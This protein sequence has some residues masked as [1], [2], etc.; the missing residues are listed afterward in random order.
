MALVTVALELVLVVTTMLVTAS[1]VVVGP[2]RIATALSEFRWRLEVCLLP[3]AAL[4][5]VLFVRWAT[6]DVTVRLEQRVIGYNLT[7]HLFEIE[8]IVF[9]ENPVAVLQ[10]F[11][12]P[13]LTSFFV[14]VYIYGYAFLLLFPFVAY[15][16]LD[17]MEELSTLL[18]SYTANY[19]IGLGCYILFMAFGPSNLAPDFFERLLYDAFPQAAFLTYQVNQPTNVFPSLHTS[20]SVTVFLLA[21]LTRD[22]YPVWVP[23][24]GV[25]AGSVL[26]STMYL[27]IHWFSDVVAGTVLAV[28]SVYIGRNYTV[29]GILHGVRDYV[30]AR[31]SR[32]GQPDSK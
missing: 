25:L 12:S 28:V 8:R 14:F 7:P 23:I 21:W 15:F 29:A 19:G 31:L 4:A 6:V 22:E 30:D 1:L 11:Q 3:L 2:R 17:R 5:A 27:G 18:L 26:L 16:S 24:A 20:L 32:D 13:E 9:P 10:S